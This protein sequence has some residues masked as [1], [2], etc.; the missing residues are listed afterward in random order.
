MRKKLSVLTLIFAVFFLLISSGLVFAQ[1]GIDLKKK[2]I[3]IAVVGPMTG[4]YAV[5]GQDQKLG[6]EFAIKEVNDAGGI[7]T[8][9][10]KGFKLEAAYLDDKGD[11]K[12]SGNV[13]Q[14]IVSGNYFAELGPTNSSPASVSAPILNRAKVPMIITYAADIRLTRSGY[15]NIFR[16]G[17]QTITEAQSYASKIVKNLG[18]K[19]IAEIWENTAYGQSLHQNF[20]E[21]ATSLGAQVV[22]SETFVSGQDVDFKPILTKMKALN[23]DVVMLNVTYN[24]GGVII[25]QARSMGW[26][27]PM[28]GCASCNNA[29]F[30][31]MMPPDH[32]EVYLVVIFNHLSSKPIVQNFIQAYKSMHNTTEVPSEL[33]AITRDAVRTLVEAIELGATQR[34]T[35]LDYFRKVDFQ[36]VVCQIRFDEYGDVMQP[37]LGLL[38]LNKDKVWESYE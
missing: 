18:K 37:D 3:K 28:V 11:P 29:K 9:K 12:E 19:K 30:V 5:Y 2:S 27:I 36:G 1:K 8:G 7:Q 22:A 31:E 35:S 32:G 21:G 13:A 6:V 10:Y 25:S 26:Q 17:I 23:P 15:K 34:E 24:D 20:V 33:A 38:K 4:Q 14:Q 16:V